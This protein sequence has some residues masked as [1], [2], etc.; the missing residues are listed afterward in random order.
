M[1]DDRLKKVKAYIDKN[2]FDRISENFSNDYQ[3][4]IDY[5]KNKSNKI[6]AYELKE[7]INLENRRKLL[8]KLKNRD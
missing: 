7:K 1:V 3:F 8:E 4:I 6:L 5:I 2:G